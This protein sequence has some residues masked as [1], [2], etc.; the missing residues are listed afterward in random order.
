MHREA[1]HMELLTSVLIAGGVCVCVGAVKAVCRRLNQNRKNAEQTHARPADFICGPLAVYP[2]FSACASWS[3]VSQMQLAPASSKTSRARKPQLTE[4][5]GSWAFWA[6]ATS[7][8][9]SPM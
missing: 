5:Q 6:V 2:F 8:S 4:M 3:T 1:P 9:E 7:T